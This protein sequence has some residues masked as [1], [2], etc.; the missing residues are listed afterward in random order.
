MYPDHQP[1]G[2]EAASA[3][4]SIKRVELVPVG[5]QARQSVGKIRVRLTSAENVRSDWS[6]KSISQALVFP[7]IWIQTRSNCLTGPG[8]TVFCLRG[9]KRSSLGSRSAHV[10]ARAVKRQHEASHAWSFNIF[11]EPNRSSNTTRSIA[12]KYNSTRL[13]HECPLVLILQGCRESDTRARTLLRALDLT[14]R[15]L[16]R[17]LHALRCCC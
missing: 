1:D 9:C 6:L 10:L 3:R 4:H 13:D 12:V 16:L 2:A 8:L 14:R 17:Y 15:Q 5:I 7:S 11:F